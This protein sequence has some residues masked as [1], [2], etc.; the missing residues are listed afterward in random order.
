M[1]TYLVK[2]IFGPTLQ[3]EGTYAGTV[4]KFLRLAGCNKWTG[5]ERHKPLSMCKF[6]D[7]DFVGGQRLTAAEVVAQLEELPGPRRVVITGGEPT[8]Q[9]DW[10]LTHALYVAGYELHLETNGSNALDDKVLRVLHH[11]TMSPKQ[12]PHETK[13]QMC[14][15][16]KLLFPWIAPGI[17]ADSYAMFWTERGRWLQPLWAERPAE[18]LSNLHATIDELYRRP[19]FRLSLQTHK[20]TGVR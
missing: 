16:L 18:T 11:I 9:L 19:N 2:E 12:P 7:T 3:G 6:C 13:L 15:D 1:S 5:K 10:E 8:L 17:D 14:H 20:F 4:V